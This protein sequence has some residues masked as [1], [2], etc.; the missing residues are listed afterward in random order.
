MKKGDI[1][2]ETVVK[3]IL[4]FVILL[5]LVLIFFGLKE[6]AISELF[7]IDLSDFLKMLTGDGG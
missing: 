5:I 3:L 7:K 2:I 6:K 4:G 1:S